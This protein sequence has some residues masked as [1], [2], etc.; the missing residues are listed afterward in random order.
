M[1]DIE[2]GIRSLVEA[3]NHSGLVETFSSCEGHFAADEQRLR[4]RNHAEVRFLPLSAA[5]GPAIEM[6]LGSLLARF[7]SR[8]GLMPVTVVGYKLF[9]P[10]DETTVE[11]TYVLELHPFNRFDPPATKRM[12]IDRAVL[13]LAILVTPYP[14]DTA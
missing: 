3:L 12:D 1:N 13:Q 7:K 9:T 2:P 11:E 8:H 10:I 6:W 14:G 4:D 5:S